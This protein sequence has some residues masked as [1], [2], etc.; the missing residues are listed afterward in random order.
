MDNDFSDAMLA[1]NQWS[2][3]AQQTEDI[4]GND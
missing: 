2:T 3:S 4:E 1:G